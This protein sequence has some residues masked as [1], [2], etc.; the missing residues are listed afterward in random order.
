MHLHYYNLYFVV[1][2]ARARRRFSKTYKFSYKLIQLHFQCHTGNHN[3]NTTQS[4][5]DHQTFRELMSDGSFSLFV[6]TMFVVA[7]GLLIFV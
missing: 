2:V 7:V 1:R 4:T 5:N 3:H 6:V